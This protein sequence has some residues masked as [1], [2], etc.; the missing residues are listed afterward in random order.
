MSALFMGLATIF[1]P[2]APVAGAAVAAGAGAAAAAGAAG[3]AAGG[4]A[5]S[6]MGLF[7]SILSG[8]GQALF[9]RSEMR[10]EEKQQIAAEQRREARYEGVG[11]ATRFWEGGD[12]SEGSVSQGPGYQRVDPAERTAAGQSVSNSGTSGGL[13]PPANGGN[14]AASRF[15]YNPSTGR[16]E[17]N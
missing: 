17:R 13:A 12:E 9:T 11:E 4:L 6:G 5:G 3:V 14:P 7:G 15:Q 8:V 10:E 16:I 1:A 2:A